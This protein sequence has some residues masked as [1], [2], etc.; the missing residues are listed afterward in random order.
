MKEYISALR[1]LSKI[2][3]LGAKIILGEKIDEMI[4]SAPK[5]SLD[6]SLIHEIKT[7]KTTILKLI[8]NQQMIAKT[9]SEVAENIGKN[10]HHLKLTLQ[11]RQL[12]AI[13]NSSSHDKE[14]NI[15]RIIELRN[16]INAEKLASNLVDKLNNIHYAKSVFQRTDNGIQT[17][18]IDNCIKFEYEELNLD[19]KN[20]AQFLSELKQYH[21]S[22]GEK[23][24]RLYLISIENKNII[25]F[26][27]HHIICDGWS[28]AK[29]LSSAVNETINNSKNID[30][31]YKFSDINY[32]L[33][34]DKLIENSYYFQND[35]WKAYLKGANTSLNLIYQ[36]NDAPNK[37][38]E[39]YI[40]TI[41][42]H[43]RD[44]I[45]TLSKMLK[46]TEYH[47][48]KLCLLLTLFN[49]SRQTDI[50][51]G[52]TLAKREFNELED[53]FGFLSRVI[54]FR[55]KLNLE[56][57]I[58]NTIINIKELTLLTVEHSDFPIF[59]NFEN[60]LG[61]HPESA[62]FDVLMS[63][64][65]M[66]DANHTFGGKILDSNVAYTK[67][68]IVLEINIIND[69]ITA[70]FEY[71]KGRISSAMASSMAAFF[72]TI[73]SRIAYS[74]PEKKLSSLL[75]NEKSKDTF[76]GH[77][78]KI[79]D[80]LINKIENIFSSYADQYAIKDDYG[81]YTYH[82]ISKK[83]NS[84]ISALYSM[85]ESDN[86]T[87]AIIM[88]QDHRLIVSILACMKCGK[89]FSLIVPDESMTIIK[90]KL[91]AL[92]QVVII[93]DDL[94]ETVL[95]KLA[96]RTINYQQAISLPEHDNNTII[97]NKILYGV[98]TSGTTG[99][100]KFAL[101]YHTSFTNLMSWYSSLLQNTKRDA[102]IV[103]SHGFDL[104]L[105]NLFY[106]F[107]HGGCLYLRNFHTYD[108]RNIID[109]IEE[110]QVEFINLSPTQFYSLLECENYETKL[111]SIKNIILG[112]EN[113]DTNKIIEY[114]LH[115]SEVN[116]INTYGPCEAADIV[117]YSIFP[118]KEVISYNTVPLTHNLD[119]CIVR[120][121][122]NHGLEVPAGVKGEIFISGAAVGNGY[123]D[124]HL[125]K[126][127]FIKKDHILWYKTG[128]I[129]IYDQD[130][131]LIIVGRA[132]DQFKINGIRYELTDVEFQIKQALGH[133]NLAIKIVTDDKNI[134]RI[135]AYLDK[136]GLEKT[137]L[138]SV[139]E[140]LVNKVPIW[141]QPVAWQG[142]E[143]FPMSKNGKLVRKRLPDIIIEHYTEISSEIF[144][145]VKK[146]LN[147][148]IVNETSNLLHYGAD[149]IKL[150]RLKAWIQRNHKIEISAYDMFRSTCLED[151]NHIITTQL[152]KTNKYIS[153]DILPCQFTGELTLSPFE[154][155]ILLAEKFQ[156]TLGLYSNKALYEVTRDLNIEDIYTILA[157]IYIEQ[158]S[159]RTLF[160]SGD[161][162][163]SI[164]AANPECWPSTWFNIVNVQDN[165][166][167]DS[168][169]CYDNFGSKQINLATDL[170]LKFFIICINNRVSHIYLDFHHIAC[171]QKSI[172]IFYKRFYYFFNNREN[173]TANALPIITINNYNIDKI[174]WKK[175]LKKN[176][177]IHFHHENKDNSF[178]NDG[179]Y[180][181]EKTIDFITIETLLS[182][183]KNNDI[184]LHTLLLSCFAIS[185]YLA[186][187][188]SNFCIGFP[189]SLRDR[190]EF[191]QQIGCFINML[192]VKMSLD[193]NT[194]IHDI[195]NSIRKHL[196]H[197][198]N[199]KFTPLY[200]IKK[201]A[202][203]QESDIYNTMLVLHESMLKDT[204]F[205]NEFFKNINIQPNPAR[206]DM[207][208]HCLPDAENLTFKFEI[209][210]NVSRHEVCLVADLFKG[211]IRKIKHHDI[212]SLSIKQFIH[213]LSV[214]HTPAINKF[215]D[216]FE[217]LE[218]NAVEQPNAAALSSNT[219]HIT[220]LEL[221][222]HINRISSEINR[223]SIVN[224]V[225]IIDV[226][227]VDVIILILS[228]LK[229][230][231]TFTV[232]NH[233]EPE[234]RMISLFK[235]ANIDTI[236]TTSS[237]IFENELLSQVNKIHIG[238]DNNL[239]SLD[240]L[241]YEINKQD[242][243]AYIIFTSGSTGVPKGVAINYLSLV[244]STAT[245]CAIYGEHLSKFLLL[246]PLTFDSAYA[247]V[248]GC[249]YYG[250]EI[251]TLNDKFK[252]DP[253]FITHSCIKFRPTQSLATPSLY[254]TLMKINAG[255]KI[256]KSLI[257]AGEKLTPQLVTDHY[258]FNPDCELYNEYGPSENTIWSTYHLCDKHESINHEYVPIGKAI[259]GC[260]AV[261]INENTE[262]ISCNAIGELCLGG[263]Y[264]FNSYIGNHSH[265]HEVVVNIN[266][267]P[268]TLYKTGDKV[269]MNNDGV[270]TY[271]SRDNDFIKIRGYRVSLAE[272][273][274]V[275]HNAI[276]NCRSRAIYYDDA[277]YLFIEGSPELK[278]STITAINNKLPK[279]MH[280]NDY[281]FIDIFP[282]NMNG[283]ICEKQLK[284][285]V[286]KKRSDI[287]YNS[288][289]IDCDVLAA[290]KTTLGHQSIDIHKTFFENGGDS[291]KLMSLLQL[292]RNSKGQHIELVT[293]YENP[294]LLDMSQALNDNS[295]SVI[296]VIDRNPNLLNS[297]RNRHLN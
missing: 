269:S 229:T 71:M 149:S 252:T 98:F 165:I 221:K 189:I 209:G 3:E 272:I 113:I 86:E 143:A 44:S 63:F 238:H 126:S 19:E 51:I 277:I 213:T 188:Q 176:E 32:T 81:Q 157:S 23:L 47:I 94:H 117:A 156:G 8:G 284:G 144:N 97:N 56:D 50:V 249:L 242:Y 35:F 70:N 227:P 230:R 290:W 168:Q 263:D 240:T 208:L 18:M 281:F 239:V 247:G 20:Y 159:L 65:N 130:N 146:E 109:F 180:I 193:G 274:M 66:P 275:V 55:V 282:L 48:Y 199:E 28:L 104:T 75:I 150:N 43:D 194:R 169:Y 67:A 26:I 39:C 261:I 68:N 287:I 152:N 271:I 220:Y 110:S 184:S 291:I 105:K 102:A 203:D 140:C 212:S 178:Y 258:Q 264:L 246:S 211:V 111:K 114:Q 195:L 255:F 106:P 232:I 279:Y 254:K 82:E 260:I 91:K 64:Q 36:I 172:D 245:R 38:A 116:I 222:N 197:C 142:I 90:R 61:Y 278:Q 77:A 59:E 219:S 250:G 24:I 268:V 225:A 161:M 11:Q 124:S 288:E 237:L 10:N 162:K 185:L 46:V 234:E 148:P 15:A 196:A 133:S 171:D 266:G 101:N 155:Q 119:N 214:Y 139:R 206:L 6:Q 236:I 118:A 187:G 58:K 265:Q 31:H 96:K 76:L 174:Y 49:Y 30:N 248:F 297:R 29:W 125:T 62:Y 183:A 296:K 122:D 115:T 151:I 22:P 45:R 40:A 244:K 167:I 4:I 190:D 135:F 132:D 223:S 289:D 201:L 154:K 192:P 241:S 7:N 92:N 79:D 14:Y 74:Q 27:A 205:N 294:T 210:N 88:P 78:Q 270:I 138:N 170:P 191:S 72:K 33:L 41:D 42:N 259:P 262:I 216:L 182:I 231:T 121:F 131:H 224:K 204:D 251:H 89:T 285:Y 108:S 295:L 228:C 175:V 179:N 280:P 200:E 198:Q 128:D 286:D 80:L 53:I 112:G 54:L 13:R 147:I 226:E 273:D 181:F 9:K 16:N 52:S 160:E 166:L 2:G 136:T 145:F 57:S 283:K 93:T 107:I 267:N 256:E 173:V 37:E 253:Q 215:E 1:I 202:E 276:P 153:F 235:I 34:Q 25:A 17:L 83:I 12:L 164:L 233:L 218:K 137:P 120:L 103:T 129:G 127:N 163:K 85:D 177:T 73:V 207:T 123:S 141:L 87:V 292:I 158:S 186:K 134:V 21:F 95:N 293:L 243:I 217:R 5:G 84:L 99:V 257:L 100:P 60:L 69:N